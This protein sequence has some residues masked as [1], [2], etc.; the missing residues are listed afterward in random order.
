MSESANRR[1]V[2]DATVVAEALTTQVVD[3]YDYFK[4]EEVNWEYLEPSDRTTVCSW[5]GTA[6]YWDVIVDGQR[7]AAAAWS[8]QE[9]SAAAQHLKGHVAFWRG[10]KVVPG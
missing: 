7:L 4:P 5:K 9:P 2:V 1:A 10:V 6:R 3:G 8:Y